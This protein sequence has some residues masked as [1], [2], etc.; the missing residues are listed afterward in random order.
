M[1]QFE[2]ASILFTSINGNVIQIADDISIKEV[3]AGDAGEGYNNEIV[4]FAQCIENNTQPEECMPVSSLQAIRLCYD[5][6]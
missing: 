2:K 6:L 3:P 1:A 4:Y 5:H